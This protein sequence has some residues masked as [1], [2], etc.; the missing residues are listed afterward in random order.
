MN[1]ARWRR[2]L[3]RGGVVAYPTESCYG[4]GCL[5]THIPALRRLLRLKRRAPAKGLIVIGANW[6]QLH[7]LL[8]PISASLQRD[9][10]LGWRREAISYLLPKSQR[11]S[12]WLCGDHAD[13]AVR[14]PRHQGARQLCRQLGHA[15]VSTSANHAGKPALRS[16]AACR[17][18]FG[19]AI[20]IWPGRVGTRRVPSKICRP[21][22]GERLR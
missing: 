14:I 11:V 22:S 9:L 18:V 2:H 19:H 7:P 17:R 12:P 16:A 1:I 3:Q 8:K 13:V 15:L 4:L 21:L 6:R 5:P 10:S 20:W